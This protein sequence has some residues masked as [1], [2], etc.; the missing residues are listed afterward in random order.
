MLPLPS[1]FLIANCSDTLRT[2]RGV[3]GNIR[4]GFVAQFA[5]YIVATLATTRTLSDTALLATHRAPG[6]SSRSLR[7]AVGVVTLPR[8]DAR[9]SCNARWDV[10]LPSPTGT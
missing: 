3:R 9:I 5:G 8:G 10:G 2:L 7:V 4:D 6:A 1:R